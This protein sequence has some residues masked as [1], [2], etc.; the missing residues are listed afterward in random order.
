MQLMYDMMVLAFQTDST[1][2]ATLLLA[3]DG[4]N[5]SFPQIGISEGHHDSDAPQGQQ[6]RCSTRSPRSTC[7]TCSSSP[8]FLEKL[9]QTKDAD[10]KSLLHNSMIVY[11]SGNA[12]GNRH[13]HDNL[14][15]VLAGSAGG[16]LTPGRYQKLPSQPLSNLY[17]GMLDKLG[18]SG[19]ALVRRLDRARREHLNAAVFWPPQLRNQFVPAKQYLRLS[20]AE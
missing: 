8:R 18:A 2:I 20:T 17:L 13:T 9:E 14:P 12:D 5:R 4:S 15:I 10:G 19:H 11:G 1:R 16:A 7:G 6:R 3:H